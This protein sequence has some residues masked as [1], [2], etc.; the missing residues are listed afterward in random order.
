MPKEDYIDPRY[1]KYMNSRKGKKMITLLRILTERAFTREE[2]KETT[3]F[4]L[5]EVRKLLLS[6]ADQNFVA[7]IRGTKVHRRRGGSITQPYKEKET[8]RP[9]SHYALTSEAM[10]LMRFDPEVR[11]RWQEIE[12]A[13]DK[14]VTFTAFDS[15]AN[16][17]YAI[18]KH[19]NLRQYRKPYYFMDQELQQV[20]LNPF[21]WGGPREGEEEKVYNEL[22]KVIKE[23]VRSNHIFSYY[24]VLEQAVS[25]LDAILDCHK[26][27]IKKMQIL[28]EV[29]EYLNKPR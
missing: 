18:Q 8:T 3:G 21:L 2:L 27:L 10:W 13:Y 24:R 4:S 17:L 26:L 20:P 16:L 15:Y 25:E 12:R 19:P 11:D 22:V 5:G 6:A 23:S 9:P 7:E 1:K 29:Q 14:T 28:P